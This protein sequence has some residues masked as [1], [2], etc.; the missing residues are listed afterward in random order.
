M[1]DTFSEGVMGSIEGDLFPGSWPSPLSLSEAL[2]YLLHCHIAVPI[3]GSFST[4]WDHL[5]FYR[6]WCA[7]VMVGVL[8]AFKNFDLIRFAFMKKLELYLQQRNFLFISRSKWQ[9]LVLL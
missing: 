1:A 7:S 6:F 2:M 3:L 5:F 9:D 8:Y 4:K